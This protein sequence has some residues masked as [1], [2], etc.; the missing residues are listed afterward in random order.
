M[1]TDDERLAR[2]LRELRRRAGQ[3]QE[4]AA[5]AAH[6]SPR[7]FR[8]VERR[9]AAGSPID[10]V[11]A[12]FEPYEARVRV[13]VWWHGAE[14]DRLL[15]EAHA[16]LVERVTRIV[17][18]RG[19]LTAPETTYSEYGERGSIDVFGM[20]PKTLSCLVAEIKS[21]FGSMEETNRQLDVKTRLAPKLCLARFG[22]HP[23]SVSRLLIL[24]N[25]ST[26]RRVAARHSATLG[27]IYPARAREIRAWL[28]QPEGAINGLW[29]VSN[30]TLPSG[31]DDDS[32][33]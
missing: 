28:R 18:M 4:E 24:P 26:V 15:D 31:E 16:A 1:L 27:A 5:L 7:I 25:D 14:L 20:E 21:T 22:Q 19:W 30:R 8:R 29:Y 33:A 23:T 2:A 3:T 12:V 11:R 13:S 6:V 17:S 10:T 32:E 9:G